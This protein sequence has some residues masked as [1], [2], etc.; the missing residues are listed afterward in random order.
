[1]NM[2][3]KFHTVLLMATSSAFAILAPGS[4]NAQ[5]AVADSETGDIIVTAQKRS[6]SILNVPAGVSVVSAQT[7]EALH[8]TQLTDVSSYVPAFQVDSGGSAGQTTI[9]IR[10]IAPIGRA[11]TVATYIDETPVG[12]STTYNGGNSFQLD[13]LPYDVERYEILRGPQGTLY[14]ASSMGGL[15]KYVLSAPSLDKF[16]VRAGGDLT[17]IKGG[18]KV[19]GGVRANVSG[20]IVEGKLGFVASYALQHAPGFIDNAVTGAQDQNS[21]EQQSARLGLYFKPLDGLTIKVN[22]LWQRTKTRGNA[23]M[24]LDGTTLRP[25]YG[26]LQD[27]NLVDQPF[28]KTIKIVSGGIEYKGEQVDIISATSYAETSVSQTQDASYSYGVA[29][30]AFGLPAGKSAYSYRLGLKKFTQELRVQSAGTGPFQ[31]TIGGFYTYED[32]TNFQSPSALTMAGVSIPGLDPIFIARLPSTYKEYAAFGN[33]N[34]SLTDQLEVFGGLRYAQNRQV[35]S[36]FAT[37]AILPAPISQPN[38]KSK[39]NVTTYSVGARFKPTSTTMVYARVATGYRPGGPNLA[40]P[41][42][43]PMFKSDKLTN[44]EVGVKAH[45]TDNM[46]AIDAAAFLIDW[47]DIQLLTNGGGAGF[48]YI[49]NGTKA[50]SEGVEANLTIRPVAGLDVNGTFAYIHSVLSADAPLAGGVKGDRLPSIPKLSGSV[51]AS[52]TQDLVADWS[53]TFGFGLRLVD[54]RLADF[55]QDPNTGLPAPRYRLPGYAALDLNASVT[56]GRYTFRLFAKN[57]TD[58]RAYSSYNA[59]NNQAFGN[60]TQVNAAIIQ[61]RTIGAAFDVKF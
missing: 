27:N 48:N 53:G 32:S 43:P 33:V 6:E 4:A 58:K 61:P 46:F 56:D 15:L 19:G 29:F 9:S 16:A 1:M 47:K 38:Q 10:G 54:R 13:L 28:Q 59:Q 55:M 49:A 11:S 51:S 26:D 41:G 42:V 14:G 34:Y 23:T 17:G 45:T 20:P 40:I 8:A 2:R 30:A 3:Y 25:L 22:G 5:T 7:L 37:G 24:P 39:E 60:I 44:Y 36:E 52:Y 57:I 18:G 12:S 50:R 35:F 31:W 21:V